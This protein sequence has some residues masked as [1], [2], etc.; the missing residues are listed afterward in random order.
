LKAVEPLVNAEPVVESDLKGMRWFILY[1]FVTVCNTVTVN[2]C[3]MCI[4]VV[5]V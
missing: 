5:A 2:L 1:E 3:V 4:L